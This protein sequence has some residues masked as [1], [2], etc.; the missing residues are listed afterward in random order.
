MKLQD[1]QNYIDNLAQDGLTKITVELEIDTETTANTFYVNSTKETYIYGTERDA[2]AK[3]DDARQL[4]GFAA[5]SKKFKAGKISKK[6]GEEL[7]P[8][9]YTVV[10][11]LTH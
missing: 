3:I 6:T 5:A 9:T 7:T 8:D 4:D 2:D 1:L 11:K 10:V